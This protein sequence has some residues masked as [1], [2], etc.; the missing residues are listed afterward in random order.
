[1]RL[2]IIF[3]QGKRMRSQGRLWFAVWFVS[4]GLARADSG[5]HDFQVTDPRPFGYVIG[6]VLERRVS[7]EVAKPLL[8]QSGKLPKVGRSNAWLELRELK[9]SR[10][11][12]LNAVR[13]ELVFAYQLLNS[14]EEIKTL[15]LPK[16]M[17][18]FAGEDKTFERQVPEFLFTVAP[19]TP[20]EPLARAGLDILRHDRPPVPV[21][22]AAHEIVLA[23]CLAS[24][25]LALFYLA[26]LRF[27]LPW[28]RS[29]PFARAYRQVR[30]LANKPGGEQSFRE[31]L[32]RLHRAFDQTAGKTLF[33][34]QLDAFFMER[35]DF[36]GL[37][38]ATEQFFEL[39]HR[40]FFGEG[41]H[42]RPMQWLLA[43]CRDWRA[44]EA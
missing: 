42:E 9:S 30:K 20:V 23:I 25:V 27:G 5:I 21:P 38:S 10:N 41:A 39:S 6:D 2:P 7:L 13:Y 16:I 34:E 31:A 4:A 15:E 17:L 37:K 14:P 26:I 12:D 8:L 28:Q 3:S 18:H 1:M 40:E 22:T 44:L 33:A 29:R 19:I 11:D 35:P 36:G 32:Q 43:F 24:T